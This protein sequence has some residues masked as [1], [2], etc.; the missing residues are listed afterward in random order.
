MR[1]TFGLYSFFR[2]GGGGKGSLDWQAQ[3]ACMSLSEP[4][5][6]SP[7]KPRASFRTTTIQFLVSSCAILVVVDL[8]LFVDG[9]L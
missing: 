1:L 8:T 6:M 3:H 4:Q 2:R 9:I 5:T 7:P